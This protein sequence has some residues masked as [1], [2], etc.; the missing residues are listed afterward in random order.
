MTTTTT[1]RAML[2]IGAALPA[3]AISSSWGAVPD[4]IFAAI[5]THGRA[6]AAYSAAVDISADLRD[7]DPEH[8]AAQV[9]TDRASTA[10][11][12]AGSDLA[13]IEPTTAAGLF[14]LLAYVT[15]LTDDDE[16]D[17]GNWKLPHHVPCNDGSEPHF[18]HYLL[19]SIATTLQNLTAT[20]PEKIGGRA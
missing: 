16:F 7:A 19:C 4:P 1:R 8:D 9:V 17:G 13:G 5:E 11:E 6:M 3:L 20:G 12:D 15:E 2:A 18:V 10:L 14:A